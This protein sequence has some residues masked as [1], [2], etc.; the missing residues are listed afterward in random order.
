V[1]VCASDHATV[2]AT[3]C[4]IRAHQVAAG[5]VEPDGAHAGRQVVGAGDEIVTTRNGLYAMKRGAV[6]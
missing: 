3:S 1:V 2:D 4:R 6:S 5:E